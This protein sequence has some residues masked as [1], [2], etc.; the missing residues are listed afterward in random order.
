MNEHDEFSVYIP[1]KGNLF[2][3]FTF[4][5]YVNDGESTLEPSMKYNWGE[6][7]N[8]IHSKVVYDGKINYLDFKMP[9]KKE[10]PRLSTNELKRLLQEAIEVEDYRKA[11][12]L[13]KEIDSREI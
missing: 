2:N 1:E 3:K 6:I 12:E 7:Q 9:N 13:K 10:K 11:A 8:D 4:E 5:A